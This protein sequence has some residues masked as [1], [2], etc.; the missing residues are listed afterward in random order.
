MLGCA[1]ETWRKSVDIGAING[2]LKNCEPLS[3]QG[4]IEID[5]YSRARARDREREIERERRYK[6]REE[7]RGRERG[8]REGDIVAK[9]TIIMVSYDNWSVVSPKNDNDNECM[10]TTDCKTI[11]TFSKFISFSLHKNIL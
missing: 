6:G 9:S 7:G 3:Q 4:N 1:T 10:I 8:S 11:L 2:R 5:L